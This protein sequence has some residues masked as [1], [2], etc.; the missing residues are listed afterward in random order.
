MVL[1][2]KGVFCWSRRTGVYRV[3][4]LNRVKKPNLF[5]CFSNL[6]ISFSPVHISTHLSTS[7]SELQA[8]N[9]CIPY[10]TTLHECTYL[11]YHF[12]HVSHIIHVLD[13][14]FFLYGLVLWH[15]AQRSSF[16]IGLF[17]VHVKVNHSK[18]T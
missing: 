12:E 3:H 1:H 2:Y 7:K 13:Q 15:F 16:C 8:P 17:A 11:W 4:K 18:K 5:S 9:T 6:T 10:S 14:V